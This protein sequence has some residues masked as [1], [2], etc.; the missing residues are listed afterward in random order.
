[1]QEI[2]QN[3]IVESICGGFANTGGGQSVEVSISEGPPSTIRWL[4]LC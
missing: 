2:G 1:M 4:D 3:A